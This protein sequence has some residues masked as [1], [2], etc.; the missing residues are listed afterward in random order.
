MQLLYVLFFV[1]SLFTGC[2]QAADPE[3]I[4]AKQSLHDE[5]YVVDEILAIVYHPEGNEIIL[6]SDLQPGIDGQVKTFPEIVSEILMLQDARK[7]KLSVTDD[8]LDRFLAGIQKQNGWARSELVDFFEEHGYTLEEG[9]DLLR[10]KQMVQQVVDY[11]IRGDKR[12]MVQREDA[13]AYYE[14]HPFFEEATYT[15]AI[16]YTPFS[17]YSKK[18]LDAALKKKQA[19]ADVVW[20]E[21]FILKESELAQDR[22]F[23][24]NEAVGDVVLKEDVEGGYEL[25]KLVAKT[26]KKQ[27]PFEDK[28]TEIVALMRQ[29]RFAA[30][31]KDYQDEL[32]KNAHI[33]YCQSEIKL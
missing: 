23:I 4:D 3:S 8:E 18:T 12:M 28:Y 19:P 6:R 1:W 9:K 33:K 2:A 17:K 31:L 24:V 13:L 5:T 32:L 20:D 15:L 14:V 16:T 25:T 22:K 26:E 30:I 11:K 27:I 10:N 21:P 7:F 29:E